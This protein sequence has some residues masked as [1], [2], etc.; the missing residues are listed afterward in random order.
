MRIVKFFLAAVILILA[1]NLQAQFKI[2]PKVGAN[3]T[4]I[5]GKS[6]SDE[7]QYNYLVG[8]FAEIG[9]GDKFSINPEVIFN[10]TSSTTSSQFKSIY[11]DVAS[12][13]QRKAKLNYLSI[14][15]L[16]DYRLFGPL[17]LQAGP[18]FSILTRADK[19]LLNNGEEAFKS[20]EFSVV[21]GAQLKISSF[22]LSGRYVIGL[23]NINDI[24][25]RDDWRNQAWQ[26]SVGYAF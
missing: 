17:H 16:M 14:P 19:N 6:F 12:G 20:G 2:G 26:L 4:K 5:E 13:D 22:R 3:I 9:F 11:E 8:A 7:F 21:G 23:N 10:Q 25:N 15:V 1:N 18:Q 24:D